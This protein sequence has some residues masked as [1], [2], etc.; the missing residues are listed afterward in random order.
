MRVSITPSYNIINNGTDACLSNKKKSSRSDFI[1]SWTF[2]LYIRPGMAMYWI[3]DYGLWPYKWDNTVCPSCIHFVLI[4]LCAFQHVYASFTTNAEPSNLK[5]TKNA[6]EI[7]PVLDHLLRSKECYDE[8]S[9]EHRISA[10]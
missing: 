8:R 6:V 9:T 7:M 2:I 5:L 3:Q 10:L 4:F 1:R